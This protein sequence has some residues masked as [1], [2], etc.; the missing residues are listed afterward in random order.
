MALPNGPGAI[1]KIPLQGKPPS[2]LTVIPDVGTLSGGASIAQS[3]VGNVGLGDSN[4]RKYW[5]NPLCHQIGA[6]QLMVIELQTAPSV[7][8]AKA[9][10]LPQPADC[11]AAQTH[12][13]GLGLNNG[14]VYV[15][16]VCGGPSDSDLKGYV[17]EYNGGALS[18]KLAFPFRLCVCIYIRA[19]CS[20]PPVTVC[21][22]LQTGQPLQ[23][24]RG[25]NR[26]RQYCPLADRHRF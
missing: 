7:G 5:E 12:P 21:S 16:M 11:T 23:S 4:C 15:G 13:F 10:K 22:H 6:K 24:W 19:H 2:L 8:S 14:K 9:Q 17:Y 3:D 1:Y 25:I 18:K 20:I 26:S